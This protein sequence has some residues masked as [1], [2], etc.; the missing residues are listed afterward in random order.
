MLIKN[1][2]SEIYKLQNLLS[3]FTEIPLQD[4]FDIVNK[5]EDIK[6]DGINNLLKVKPYTVLQ[7]LG[8]QP[9]LIIQTG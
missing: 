7:N 1:A 9:I 8:G 4:F 3:E 2:E 6:T 5:Y